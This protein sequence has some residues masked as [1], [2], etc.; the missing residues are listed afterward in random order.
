MPQGTTGG[1]KS[2]LEKQLWDDIVS[3]AD[4][5][6]VSKNKRKRRARAADKL[7]D[8]E[9]E[10]DLPDKLPFLRSEFATKTSEKGAAGSTAQPPKTFLSRM[11]ASR[12]DS[13]E[14]G[15]S[16]SSGANSAT[17]AQAV[18][19]PSGLQAAASE[20]SDTPRPVEAAESAT[21]DDTGTIRRV[22]SGLR[23]RTL[24]QASRDVLVTMVEQHGGTVIRSDDARDNLDDADFILVRLHE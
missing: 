15:T 7:S 11:R 6:A 14:A 23:L 24:G 18:A 3:N 17:S 8:T 20:W 10:D 13:Y 12:V 19:G 9:D 16:A 4:Q 22:F 2:I 5:N 21:M 1:A